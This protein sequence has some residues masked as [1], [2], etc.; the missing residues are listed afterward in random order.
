ML[1]SAKAA[2]TEAL[3]DLLERER[4]ALLEGDFEVL[5][6]IAGEKERLLRALGEAKPTD[7]PESLRDL[8]AR[9]GE[10]LEAVQR[11]LKA[12]LQRIEA[13]QGGGTPL[14]SYDGSGSA[15]VIGPPRPSFRR[16]V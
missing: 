12:G 3:I 11:G 8:A 7:V 16:D 14:R 15:A 6:R 4:G 5:A 9:N 13:L 2:P 1:G 10:L